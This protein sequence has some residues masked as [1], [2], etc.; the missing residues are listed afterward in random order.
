[1]KQNLTKIRNFIIDNLKWIVLF[2]CIGVSRIYL[3]VHY[4]SDVLAGFLVAISYLIVYIHCTKSIVHG[5]EEE[6]KNEK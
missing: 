6:K 2:I 1:M 4:T 5:R 3:G